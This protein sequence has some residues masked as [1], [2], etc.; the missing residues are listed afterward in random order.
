MFKKINIYKK[1]QSY[2]HDLIKSYPGINS[3]RKR[4]VNQYKRVLKNILISQ[5]YHH[6]SKG[7]S[8]YCFKK[9]KFKENKK[10]LSIF[11]EK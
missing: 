10:M 7:K 2:L 1:K 11:F 3:G 9:F 5:A 4:Y 8:F 6:I